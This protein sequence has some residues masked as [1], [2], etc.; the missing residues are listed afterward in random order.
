MVITDSERG[1]LLKNLRRMLDNT[2]ILQFQERSHKKRFENGNIDSMRRNGLCKIRTLR[3]G[4][5]TFLLFHNKL[6]QMCP[7]R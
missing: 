3:L 1:W 5:D 6:F 4:Y 7:N 2:R